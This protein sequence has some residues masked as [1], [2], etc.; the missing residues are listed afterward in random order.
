MGN[1]PYYIIAPPYTR[2]SAGVRVLYRLCDLINKSGNTAFIYQRP[3]TSPEIGTSPSDV[4][5]LLNRKIIDYHFN[6]GLTPIV[7]YPETFDVD[8]FS[9]PFR[10]KYILNF[11]NYLFYNRS[12]TKDDYLLAYSQ[13]ISNRLDKNIPSSILN[14]L[15]SDSSFFV[16]PR[17]EKR[18][19]GVFYAGKFKDHFGGYTLPITDGMTEITRDRP[20]SQSPEE[21]RRLFQTAE[22]FY[23]YED[24][25][26]VVEAM[27]CGCPVVFVPNEFFKESLA[28]KELNGIGYAWGATT[29]QMK[30]AQD[31]VSLFRDWY[32]HL[33]K[34]SEIALSNFIS[35]SQSLVK[36]TQ[37]EVPFAI[38]FTRQPSFITRFLGAVRIMFQVCQDKGWIE[39]AR[40]VLRRLYSCRVSFFD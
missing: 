10:V 33:I 37:Y 30:H 20:N 11:E 9:A 40:I 31:T 34:D 4:A 5:P 1:N 22:F 17:I 18:S 32:F 27:L 13:S 36:N 16:P 29:E 19:G 35:D 26:L 39:T 7:I 15:V 28:K 23:S 12:K 25:S 14:L 21:I 2:T 38:D 24:T 8:S 6:L 3:E